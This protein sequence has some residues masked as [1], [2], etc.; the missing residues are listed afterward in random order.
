MRSE[1]AAGKQPRMITVILRSCGDKERDVRRLRRVY[2]K[3]TSCPGKDR[4][5]LLIF[6][7]GSRYQMEFPNE[8]TGITPELLRALYDLVGE[9]NVR[10]DNITML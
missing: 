2:G 8:T 5:A 3:L 7:G 6:E 10:V 4:F 1:D 9:E